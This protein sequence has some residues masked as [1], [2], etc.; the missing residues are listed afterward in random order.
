MDL[1]LIS[2]LID[3]I[4]RNAALDS[5]FKA[6]TWVEAVPKIAAVTPA[7]Q[8]PLLTARKVKNKHAAL[9]KEYSI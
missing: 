1:A 6:S 8:R 4:N 5:S 7:L 3:V 9:R 2:H